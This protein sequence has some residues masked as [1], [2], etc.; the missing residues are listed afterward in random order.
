[1]TLPF[2]GLRV[3]G[4]RLRLTRSEGSPARQPKLVCSPASGNSRLNPPEPGP[5]AERIATYIVSL[6]ANPDASEVVEMR[7]EGSGRGGN[8]ATGSDGPTFSR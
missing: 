5:D 7:R 3:L 1:M 4:T 6:T 8:W 2:E